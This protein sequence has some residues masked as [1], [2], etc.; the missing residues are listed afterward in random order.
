MKKY[1]LFIVS[2]LILTS[3]HSLKGSLYSQDEKTDM[4]YFNK[5]VTIFE[6]IDETSF[7]Y[8]LKSIDTTANE[9]KARYETLNSKKE[10]ILDFAFEQFL[11]IIEEYPNSKVYHKSLYNLAYISSLEDDEDNEIKYL[12]MILESNANDKENSGR[13]GIMSNPYANFKNHASKRLTAIYLAKGEFKTALNFKQ[14]N[15][16][17]PLQHFCGNAFA[18]DE[19]YSAIQY[20]EIFIGLGEPQ[21]ALSY[22][23]PNIFNNGLA[24]N[25]DLVELTAKTLKDNYKLASLI[26]D[27]KNSIDNIYSRVEKQNQNT[28]TNYYIK[29]LDTEIE[30]PIWE[31]GYYETDSEK[32][33]SECEKIISE[34][35]FYRTLIE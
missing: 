22:L 1:Y 27:F 28:W 6:V 34:S 32:M 19:I 11:K 21:K 20:A 14:I 5:G 30:I 8:D 7:E 33:K 23:L 2:A 25:S 9:G 24:D 29:Y 12:K 4:D 18:E 35:E 15:E 10:D 31:I 16:K 13:S 17:Y 3:C 26:K